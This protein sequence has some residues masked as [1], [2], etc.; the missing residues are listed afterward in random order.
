[1]FAKPLFVLRINKLETKTINMQKHMKK[2]KWNQQNPQTQ[3]QNKGE[4]DGKKRNDKKQ[5]KEKENMDLSICI[6]VAFISL[7]RFVFF[8]CFFMLFFASNGQVHLFSVLMCFFPHLFCFLFFFFGFED[9][10]FDF[11]FVFLL[12][13]CFSSVKNIRT[14]NRGESRLGSRSPSYGSRMLCKNGLL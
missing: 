7:C 4:R 2:Q 3:K 1:M 14:N 11:P 5:K 6:F 12:F 8:C 10:L 13:C 9:L